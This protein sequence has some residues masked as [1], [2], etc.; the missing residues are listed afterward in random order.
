LG[1]VGQS[2]AAQRAKDIDG[3]LAVARDPNMAKSRREQNLSQ[4]GQHVIAV[5]DNQDRNAFE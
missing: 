3:V 5:L 2:T 1:R 4:Q